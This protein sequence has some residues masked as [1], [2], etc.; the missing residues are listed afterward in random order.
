MVKMCVIVVAGPVF[1]VNVRVIA[2]TGPALGV[3]VCYCGDRSCVWC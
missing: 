1:G 2:V 3:N